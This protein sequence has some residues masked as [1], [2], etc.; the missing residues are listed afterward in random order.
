MESV[1]EEHK[2]PDNWHAQYLEQLP[3][4]IAAF[5]EDKRDSSFARKFCLVYSNTYFR[6]LFSIESQDINVALS[7]LVFKDVDT[8]N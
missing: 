4:G 5:S 6:A 7:Q 3:D 2:A 1:S 8:K